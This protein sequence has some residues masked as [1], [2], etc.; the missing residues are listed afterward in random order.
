[1]K[2]IA[3]AAL[4]VKGDRVEKGA[5]IE[6]SEVE[7]QSFVDVLTPAVSAPKAE[8][9][10]EGPEKALADLSLS[11]LQ[12]EAK[13]LGLSTSGRK[14]D[15]VERIEIYRTSPPAEETPEGE[16]EEDAE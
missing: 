12:E 2:Y 15:L 1:M 5:E 8:K 7:A 10:V 9:V 16:S 6:L 11:E 13:S 4:I 14:S 3:Q